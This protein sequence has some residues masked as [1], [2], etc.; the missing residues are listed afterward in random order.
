MLVISRTRPCETRHKYR[1]VLQPRDAFDQQRAILTHRD[2]L[3]MLVLAAVVSTICAV[4]IARGWYTATS[5]NLFLV[6][7]A[8]GVL[9][10]PT[11]TLAVSLPPSVFF[12]GYILTKHASLLVRWLAILLSAETIFLFWLYI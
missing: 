6:Q 12:G 5:V 8:F 7:M 4:N 3:L 9:V 2:V 10:C 11:L 1:F